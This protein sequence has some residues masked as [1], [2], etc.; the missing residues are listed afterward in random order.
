[1]R[2]HLLTVAFTS[3]A[4]SPMAS[5][6]PA[7][8]GYAPTWK[9]SHSQCPSARTMATWALKTN[10][11]SVAIGTIRYLDTDPGDRS[12][13]TIE[14]MDLDASDI[15]ADGGVGYHVQLIIHEALHR[16][17]SS[18][19]LTAGSRW[20]L[21]DLAIEEAI[22]EVVSRGLR[23]HAASRWGCALTGWK[24]TGYPRLA[25]WLRTTAVVGSSAKWGSPLA[26]QWVRELHSTPVEYRRRLMASYN[27]SPPPLEIVQAEI[28]PVTP[29]S[30]QGE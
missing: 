28:Q 2:K 9:Q 5:A 22:A 10:E 14:G 29:A 7:G 6:Q 17:P 19:Q 20:D 4:L 1:M 3:L 13:P 25:K 26:W 15:A 16:T 11:Y 12:H 24:V 8:V 27:V 30:E 23:D 21:Y 18:M